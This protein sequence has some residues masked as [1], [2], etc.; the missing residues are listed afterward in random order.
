M[1]RRPTSILYIGNVAPGNRGGGSIII[2]R[3]LRHLADL[4][5][6]ISVLIPD[7]APMSSEPVPWRQFVLPARHRGWP[8]F[9]AE[10]PLLCKL[11]SRF[12]FAYLGRHG[13]ERP[14]HVLTICAGAFSWLA[15]DLAHAWRAPLTTIVHDW[16]AEFGSAS[17]RLCGEYCCRRSRTVLTVSPEMSAALAPLASGRTEVLPPVSA[18]RTLPFVTWRD[19]FADKPVVAHVGAFHAHHVPYLV[20][21]AR[22]LGELGGNLLVV[23]PSSSPSLAQLRNEAGNLI[24]Q[25]Y[26]PTHQEALEFVSASACAFT[27]MYPLSTS[28]AGLPLTG[29]PSR[30]IEFAQLG[31][32]ALLAAPPGNPLR[33]WA[34]R[35]Q[36]KSAFSPDDYRSLQHALGDLMNRGSWE[37]LATD[38][39][40]AADTVFSPSAIH[41]RL[42][43]LLSIP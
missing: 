36:W 35:Q 15:A 28:S 26:F 37:S 11:R 24:H 3:H 32:P 31:L 19:D 10:F 42:A 2:D 16:W 22:G 13:V 30:F 23:C 12:I 8:P 21:L 29:F 20:S 5:H 33:R 1:T 34:E 40:R 38:T 7:G 39:R 4:G 41:Q 17:D 27:V 14:D 18:K 6:Q 25:S 43:D 9:R